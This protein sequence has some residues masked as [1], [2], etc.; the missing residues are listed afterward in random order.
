METGPMEG[1]NC[2]ARQNPQ[3]C[4]QER[5]GCLAFN[6]KEWGDFCR[7][8]GVS[9]IFSAQTQKI[10]ISL[11]QWSLSQISGSHSFPIRTQ[12]LVWQT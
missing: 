2:P 3:Y 4:L 11:I 8:K 6:R 10:F 12:T 7:L 1:M 5:G 9:V